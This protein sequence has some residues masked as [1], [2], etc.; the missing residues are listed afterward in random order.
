MKKFWDQL[1]QF[2]GFGEKPQSARELADSLMGWIG[3]QERLDESRTQAFQALQKNEISL[4]ERRKH[5]YEGTIHSDCIKI[6]AA[7][8]QYYADEMSRRFGDTN[9]L[10]NLFDNGISTVLSSAT[11]QKI[12][13]AIEGKIAQSNPFVTQLKDNLTRAKHDLH[14]FKGANG[15]Q[16]DAQ[17]VD[18]SNSLYIIL[19]VAVFEAIANIFFLRENTS[20]PKAAFLSV[21][22]A[23]INV[24]ANV[25]FGI[26]YREKNHIDEKISKAGSTYKIYA[27][28]TIFFL[29]MMIA[30]F[31]YVSQEGSVQNSS[32]FLFESA[33]LL[34]IGVILGI[35]AFNKGYSLDD[36]YPGYGPLHRK[37][38]E[39]ETQWQFILDQHADFCESTKK[40]LYRHTHPQEKEFRVHEL[41]LW[42]PFPI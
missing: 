39:L 27:F 38:Q 23:A 33:V 40:P 21:A 13:S 7:L 18:V 22:V 20:T 28:L 42:R 31:R 12:E 32:I 29:N 36:P 24:G 15:L 16:Q 4:E 11:P 30:V 19:A 34:A 37:V 26:R 14:I 2:F 25:W 5:P 10:L 41:N 6:D 3:S 35:A 17:S 9:F 8:T 1:L